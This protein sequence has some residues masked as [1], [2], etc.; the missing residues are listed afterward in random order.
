MAVG[1]IE[2]PEAHVAGAD[3]EVGGYDGSEQFAVRSGIAL[4]WR[5]LVPTVELLVIHDGSVA[6]F[7]DEVVVGCVPE[8][9]FKDVADAEALA[10]VSAEEP[11]ALQP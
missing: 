3:V 5:E 6:D 4:G 7:P 2:V 8:P 1:G 11:C 10:E 9:C